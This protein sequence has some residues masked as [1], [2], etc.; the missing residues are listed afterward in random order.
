MTAWKVLG[1]VLLFFLLLSFLRVGVIAA[2]GAELRVRLRVGPVKLTILPKREKKAKKE[3]K[4]DDPPAETEPPKEKKKRALPRLTLAEIYDLAGA[5]FGVLGRTLRRACR[6]TRID[7]LE[8]CVVFAGD[9]PAD[10]AQTYG[11][12]CAALWTFMPKLE[13]LFYIPNPSIHLDMDFQ[14]K[15]TTAEG[16][17]SVS[18]RVCDLFAILFALAGPMAKWFLRWRGAHRNDPKPTAQAETQPPAEEA[19]DLKMSETEQ[20]SA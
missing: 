19:P 2:F 11:Y 14:A 18:L 1:I 17:V 16:T 4:A 12:A 5:L 20:L 9:D 3:E 13:E 7:P 15:E 6:R 8:V 10:T